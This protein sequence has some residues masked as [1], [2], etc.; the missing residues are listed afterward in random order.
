M[1]ITNSDTDVVNHPNSRHSVKLDSG[2]IIKIPVL[3]IIIIF[4]LLQLTTIIVLVG[5]PKLSCCYPVRFYVKFVGVAL[6]VFF[7]L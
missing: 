6:Y 7:L 3:I 2:R 1:K 5:Q 4:I